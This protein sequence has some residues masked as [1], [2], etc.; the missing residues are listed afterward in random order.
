[1]AKKE[2]SNPQFNMARSIKR[3]V[4]SGIVGGAIIMLKNVYLMITLD[5]ASNNLGRS[6]YVAYMQTRKRL[7]DS[8]KLLRAIEKS[9]QRSQ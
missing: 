5:D 9:I 7:V 2:R 8:M 3:R 6:E 1:M 4:Y